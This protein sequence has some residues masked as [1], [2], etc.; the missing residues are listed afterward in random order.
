MNQFDQLDI[1]SSEN[2]VQS[3]VGTAVAVG[4][5]LTNGNWYNLRTIITKTA[6]TNQLEVVLQLWNSDTNGV[7]GTLIASNS[8]IG[9]NASVWA[10]TTLYAAVRLNNGSFGV[11][12]LDNFS[13]TQASASPTITLAGTLA[14]VNTTYGTASVLPT[15]FQIS[16]SNLTGAPGN[17]TVTPPPGYEVSLTS[18]SAYSANLSVPYSAARLAAQMFMCV[19]L[20]RLLRGPILETSPLPAAARPRKL[21]RRLLAR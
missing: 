14:A 19:W 5:T 6:T 8:Q 10:D 1:R 7:V 12:N 9:T 2:G 15:S 13:V 16:G 17:L 4:V 20:Q 18:N 11:S 3:S 21:L